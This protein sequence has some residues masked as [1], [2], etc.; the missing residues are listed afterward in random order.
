M[1]GCRIYA[2]TILSIAVGV[3]LKWS[4]QTN[5]W[6][7]GKPLFWNSNE[8]AIARWAPNMPAWISHNNWSTFWQKT[9]TTMSGRSLAVCL[10]FSW[11]WIS[12][13]FTFVVIVMNKCGIP[14]FL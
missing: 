4:N 10:G 14:Y 5:I 11:Y 3:G 7:W 12:S 9:Q 8:C 2:E 6:L 1:E 13:Q